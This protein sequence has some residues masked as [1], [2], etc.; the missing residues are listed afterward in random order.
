M[1]NVAKSEPAANETP[2]TVVAAPVTPPIAEP[3]P[4]RG[5]AEISSPFE[6]PT[7]P[8]KDVTGFA[9]TLEATPSR[10]SSSDELDRLKA[11]LQDDVQRAKLPTVQPGGSHD[12]RVR[13]ESMLAKS[14]RLFDLGQLREARHTAKVAQDLG[15]SAKLDYSPEEERPI[16]LV[17]RID[18]QL[19]AAGE[20]LAP[21][22]VG[23]PAAEPIDP[24]TEP[25]SRDQSA[26]GTL[27]GNRTGGANPLPGDR[28]SRPADRDATAT[29][30]LPP[31]EMELDPVAAEASANDAVVKANRSLTLAAV[32]DVS[33]EPVRRSV[34]D[35]SAPIAFA[36]LQRSSRE[37]ESIDDPEPP[38]AVVPSPAVEPV[39]IPRDW[40]PDPDASPEP[41]LDQVT[42]PPVDHDESQPVQF[43]SV[44]RVTEPQ[45]RL[46]TPE[47]TRGSISQT[48]AIATLVIC[49]ALAAFW[50]RRGAT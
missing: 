45:T 37:I 6:Q 19:R 44:G 25:H 43:Q 1:A 27:A 41:I 8:I 24:V 23:K 12:V 33:D 29:A 11:A 14:R 5:V 31:I 28:R 50:Y 36:P 47:A 18:D 38:V 2:E 49:S 3:Q 17:Q 13:V 10:E 48:I 26:G 22:I 35:E 20:M 34:I 16:D 21:S 39:T 42:P 46:T 32:P 4:Q 9:S 40:T 30:D 15:D 7:E